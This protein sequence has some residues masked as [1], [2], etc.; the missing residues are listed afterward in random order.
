MGDRALREDE[1]VSIKAIFDEAFPY[2][3]AIGMTYELYWDGEPTLVIPYRK[4]D[5]LR[6]KRANNDAWL[7]GVYFQ[8]AVASTLD[9]KTKYP[10]VPFD[11]GNDK[12]APTGMTVK[13]EK[14]KAAFMLFAERFNQRMHSDA[15]MQ[16]GDMSEYADR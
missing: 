6:Q 8:M 11:I 7:Q 2:Y 14:A 4:A 3:L 12:P 10:K 13:Q 15:A 5:I 9:K 1:T 16:R